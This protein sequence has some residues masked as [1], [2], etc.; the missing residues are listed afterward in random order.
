MKNLSGFIIGALFAVGLGVGG[1]TQPAKV[2]GFL[3]FFGAWDPTLMFVM[4]GAVV[5]YTIFFR[6]I[7]GSAPVLASNFQIPTNQRIDGKLIVGS[8]LFG[9]GWGLAGYCP[10]PAL[11]SLGSASRDALVFVATMVVGMA[12]FRI[13]RRVRD[14]ANQRA[15]ASSS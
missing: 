3:D 7:R 1:M 10:G 4:G 11:T 13:Y 8:A 15:A 9:V 6:V 14:S 12:L 2:I 5:M